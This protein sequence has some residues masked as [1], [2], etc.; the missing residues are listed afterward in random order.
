MKIN[1]PNEETFEE[2]V[3]DKSPVVGKV[4]EVD[5]KN[6]CEKKQLNKIN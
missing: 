4:R 5:I 6:V 1:L 3:E 2:E